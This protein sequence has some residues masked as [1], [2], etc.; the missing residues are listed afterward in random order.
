MQTILRVER[1]VIHER[2]WRTYA[3]LRAIIQTRVTRVM[4]QLRV[5]RSMLFRISLTPGASRSVAT[6]INE[7][8]VR[9]NNMFFV[10]TTLLT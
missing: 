7:H 5:R 4:L 9:I 6:W 3:C 2:A 8:D 10:F 1:V